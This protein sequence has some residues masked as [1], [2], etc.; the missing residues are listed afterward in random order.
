MKIK[1]KGLSLV[2]MIYNKA[3]QYTGIV[4]PDKCYFKR[5]NS[6]GRDRNMVKVFSLGKYIFTIQK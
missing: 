4:S 5:V 1:I 6:F 3:I 2:V